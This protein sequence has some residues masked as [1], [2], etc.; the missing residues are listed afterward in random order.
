MSIA[1]HI[2]MIDWISMIDAHDPISDRI[3]FDQFNHQSTFYD[4]LP[5]L[6]DDLICNRDL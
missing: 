5:S 2:A 4:R 1:D 3:T 6:I